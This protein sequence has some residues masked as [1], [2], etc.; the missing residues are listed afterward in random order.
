LRN[1]CEDFNNKYEEVS[2]SV[3]A[4]SRSSIG[5]RN[6]TSGHLGSLCNKKLPEFELRPSMNMHTYKTWTHEIGPVLKEVRQT[7]S[8]K[9]L[10]VGNMIMNE[11]QCRNE[12]EIQATEQTRCIE[13]QESQ[14]QEEQQESDV[15]KKHEEFQ[16]NKY[17]TEY[18]NLQEQLLKERDNQHAT[19]AE[20]EAELRNLRKTVEVK[21]QELAAFKEECIQHLKT[22]VKKTQEMMNRVEEKK[23][24]TCR[25]YEDVYQ[26]MKTQA[27]H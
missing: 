11:Q 8:D 16:F 7:L 17:H 25:F 12:F 14:L 10:E 9:I 24:Q 6:L 13:I 1:I 19:E 26:K 27:K 20:E 3:T 4:S 5:S 23:K 2:E 15:R 18:T 21:E 22:I